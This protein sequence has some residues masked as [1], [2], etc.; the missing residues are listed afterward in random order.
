MSV[1]RTIVITGASDG[2]GAVAARQLS[3][4]GHRV[5]VVGRSPEKTRRVA[6]ALDAPSHT[7]DLADLADVRRL[8]DELLAAYP[9]IDVLAN[10]AGGIFTETRTVDGH[11]ATFQV[12]HLAPFL[13]THLLMERLVESR[14]AVLQTSSMA[15]RMGRLD[16]DDLD[17]ARSWSANKAYG[18]AKLANILMTVELHRR[19][20]DEGVSAA[21][22]H[23]GVIA[24]NFANDTSSLLRIAYRTPIRRLLTGVE[25][26]AGRLT[27]LA[28]GE[29]GRDWQ[30][31]RYHERNSPASRVN[32]Q[33]ADPALAAGLWERST[34][35]L[36]L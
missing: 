14:A 33:V 34:E 1:P 21:A 6:E 9:R 15:H 20:H 25:T 17:N 23:P 4:R 7:V 2:I 36:D 10:N 24:T 11:D 29:P 5:V 30:P 19:F 28:D 8:A 35:L 12:N 3:E 31:G 13:L 22:F 27:W 18:D 26:G 32:P 16:V